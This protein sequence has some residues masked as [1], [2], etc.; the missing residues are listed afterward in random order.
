M[1]TKCLLFVLLAIPAVLTAQQD[2]PKC[3]IDSDGPWLS[4]LEVET[5]FGWNMNRYGGTN[6]EGTGFRG[7]YVNLKLDGKIHNNLTYSWRQRLNKNSDQT[8]WD[9]TDWL[10][11]KY[12]P[13]KW[14][15]ISAGKQVVAVG[16][17]EYDR[18]PID[19]YLCSEFWQHIN[20]YQ[21]GLSIAANVS[22]NDRLLFQLCNSPMRT[23][24]R[25]NKT[26][27]LSL[28]WYGNH[29]WYQSIFSA[30]AF[31]TTKGRWINYI[32]LGNKFLF[33]KNA[34]L[35][36]DYTNR[37]SSGQ[38][39]WF[40]DCTVAA[41]A[42]VKPHRTVRVSGKYTFDTNNTDSDADVYVE[43]GT[44]LHTASIGLEFFPIRKY[45][46]NLRLHVVGGYIWGR[47][48]D[49]TVSLHPNEGLH[50]DCIKLYVGATV[51]LDILNGLKHIVRK[52]T[53]KRIAKT[54][55]QENNNK[56][57]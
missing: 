45:P 19:L 24:I 15:A 55:S 6:Q 38:A 29:G 35:E 32:A 14:L 13:N 56:T 34:F 26:V 18:A 47:M 46:E 53:D 54:L 43:K 41:E 10:E 42:S 3:E 23:Y 5:R 25:D 39:F 51:N 22:K 21:L 17:W 33:S 4:R 44:R 50:S 31:Q 9:A 8:F 52:I 27:G 57:N 1:N 40:K 12:T 49:Q 7:E 36:F 30:N 2:D 37:A 16:G 48:A 20:C 11:I 28:I